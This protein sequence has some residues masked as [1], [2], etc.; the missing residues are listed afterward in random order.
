MGNRNV[1]RIAICNNWMNAAVVA[2]AVATTGQIPAR[3]AL[4][5]GTFSGPTSFVESY[6]NVAGFWVFS[7]IDELVP[8]TGSFSYET[9]GAVDLD[10]SPD[11]DEFVVPGIISIFPLDLTTTGDLRIVAQ[12]GGP[13]DELELSDADDDIGPFVEDGFRVILNHLPATT[14]VAGDDVLT[15]TLS[16]AGLSGASFMVD[17]LPAD[18]LFA[19]GQVYVGDITQFDLS[20]QATAAVPEPS[21]LTLLTLGSVGLLLVHRQRKQAVNAP[22]P[23]DLA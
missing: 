18:G 17:Q 23:L 12:R 3:G 20:V 6:V 10:P 11:R 7:D 13:V 1:R 21:S 14:Y 8:F 5:T 22:R 4:V 9:A 2:V 16:L 15:K 19:T